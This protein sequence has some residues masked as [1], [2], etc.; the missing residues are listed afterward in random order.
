MFSHIAIMR[1]IITVATLLSVAALCRT[2][3]AAN[4]PST[5]PEWSR[6]DCYPEPG[7]TEQ[8]CNARGC[9][10]C[11]TYEQGPPWCFLDETTEPTGLCS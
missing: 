5:I 10:W 1:L 2:Y 3:T 11:E 9:M 7:S 8:G 4:C 6:Q